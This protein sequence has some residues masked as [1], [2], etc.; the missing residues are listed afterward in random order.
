LEAFG[1]NEKFI[2]EE[3]VNEY[4]PSDSHIWEYIPKDFS[5]F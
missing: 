5:T 4:S 2:E 3:D 1:E